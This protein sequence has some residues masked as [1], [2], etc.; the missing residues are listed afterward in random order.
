MGFA[1]T[2][3]PAPAKINWM[4][5]VLGRRDDGFHSIETILQRIS[6][7]DSLTF[8]RSDR[9]SLSC[10]DPSI[11][12]DETNLVWRAADMM[13]SRFDAPPVAIELNK[14][15]PPGGGLG[16]GSSDAATT[17]QFMTRHAKH[18]PSTEELR[19]TAA[20]L[21]SDVPFFLSG[22][23]CYATGRGE[24]LV[25]LAEQNAIPLVLVLPGEGVMTAEAYAM[26]SE[27]RARN[28]VEM[29]EPIG[30]QACHEMAVRG[31]LG[32]TT[33]LVN[34]FES[35]IFEARPAIS[36]AFER[37]RRSGA[38][39]T[40]M[41]GSGSTIVG[42]YDSLGKRDRA[43]ERLSDSLTVLAAETR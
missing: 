25:E 5:R 41:S 27:V 14:R 24:E 20:E 19:A 2:T 12:L 39:W 35:V 13:M 1:P 43:I 40:R 6:L 30:F 33:E 22:A 3:L 18:V 26:L 7:S 21:G 17:L 42:V 9:L 4:L 10:D 15:I 32:D 31:L 38:V 37:V 23:T 34:D 8:T 11:P 28:E 36:G 16:G 29:T